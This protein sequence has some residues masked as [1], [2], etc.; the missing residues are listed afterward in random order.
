MP[1]YNE[2]QPAGK[3]GVIGMGDI[4]ILSPV[5]VVPQWSLA[6]IAPPGEF[7]GKAIS[8]A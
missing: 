5:H 3:G 4:P 6:S 8:H 1:P 2:H 7:T